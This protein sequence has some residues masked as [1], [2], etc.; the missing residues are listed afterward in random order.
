MELECSFLVWNDR[1]FY[2]HSS[3][4]MQYLSWYHKD[5]M[6]W[7]RNAEIWRFVVSLSKL[8]GRLGTPW[9]SR[10]GNILCMRPANERR[11]CNVTSSLIGWA[12]AQNDR[13]C[14]IRDC[15]VNCRISPSIGHHDDCKCSSAK[16]ALE[17]QG[18][19][20]SLSPW[21]PFVDLMRHQMDTF[22]AL[23]AICAGNSPVTGEFPAQRPVTRGFYVFFDLRLN[24]RL[25][26]SWG[27]RP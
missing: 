7:K 27:R 9:R 21:Q 2:P 3:K 8:N 23:L 24:E 6:P 17:H 18:T 5:V 20:C 1:M 25:K 10:A 13:W 22:S 26:Q 19:A 14:D 16:W 15:N 12:H 11:R 4:F